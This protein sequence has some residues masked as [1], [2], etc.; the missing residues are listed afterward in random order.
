MRELEIKIR[1]ID[2]EIAAET[3]WE[4]DEELYQVFD[5]DR[6]FNELLDTLAHRFMELLKEYDEETD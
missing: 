1:H 4:V 6:E 5:D 3:E 2:G